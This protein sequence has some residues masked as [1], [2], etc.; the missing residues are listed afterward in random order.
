M[1]VK[2][3]RTSK[4]SGDDA[5]PVVPTVNLLPPSVHK[6]LDLQKSGRVALGLG[7]AFVVVNGLLIGLG[8]FLSNGAEA[9]LTEAKSTT[10]QMQ[11][12]LKQ[13]SDA[14]TTSATIEQLKQDR[15][16]VTAREGDWNDLLQQVTAATPSGMNITVFNLQTVGAS[17]SSSSSSTAKPSA[18]NIGTVKVTAESDDLPNI[19]QWIDNVRQINGVSDVSAQQIDSQSSSSSETSA[20]KYQSQLTI[21]VSAARF[22][23]RFVSTEQGGE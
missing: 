9:D 8:T 2:L 13:N 1:A 7:I 12:T 10:Q 21:T 5:L 18:D 15:I 19:S 3:K 17:G 16:A 22:T 20:R 6:S 14:L 4:Q 23:N 11:I